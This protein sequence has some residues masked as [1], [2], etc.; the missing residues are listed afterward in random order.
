MLEM[1]ILIGLEDVRMPTKICLVILF[2]VSYT[3]FTILVCKYNK[4]KSNIIPR[5]VVVFFK[6]L[7]KDFR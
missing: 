7:K 5:I 4:F 3:I 6:H 2:W 1:K